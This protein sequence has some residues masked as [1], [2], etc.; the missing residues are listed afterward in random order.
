LSIFSYKEKHKGLI[1]VGWG[2]SPQREAYPQVDRPRTLYHG[3]KTI[4][5]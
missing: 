5:G 3:G 2:R 1:A 4:W